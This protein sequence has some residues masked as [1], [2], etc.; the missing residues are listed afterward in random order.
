MLQQETLEEKSKLVIHLNLH[1]RQKEILTNLN[2]KEAEM[3]L[4]GEKEKKLFPLN[5]FVG[6]KTRR[7]GRSYSNGATA[8][9]PHCDEKQQQTTGKINAIFFR[10]RHLTLLPIL[11]GR[12]G[13]FYFH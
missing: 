4:K 9:A 13:R 6:E 11:S 10:I 8:A 1:L 2:K 3:T 7:Q 12:N 5:L